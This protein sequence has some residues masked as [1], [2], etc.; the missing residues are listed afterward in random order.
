MSDSPRVLLLSVRALLER[1]IAEAPD[2]GSYNDCR[3]CLTSWAERSDTVHPDWCL[4]TRIRDYLKR[5]A[6]AGY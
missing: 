2:G 1:V 5:L 3:H 6:Q 4:I